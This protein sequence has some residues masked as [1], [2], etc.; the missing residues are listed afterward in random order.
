MVGDNLENARQQS[1]ARWLQSSGASG[2]AKV[3]FSDREDVLLGN[4]FGPFA[5][6]RK[7]LEEALE[8]AAA[9]YREGR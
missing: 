1:R 6:G 3:L 9:N 5:R 8:R 7:Q 2:P 4:P